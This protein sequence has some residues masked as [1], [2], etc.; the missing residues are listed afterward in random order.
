MKDK[1]HISQISTACPHKYLFQNTSVYTN[2]SPSCY[3]SL[4]TASLQHD[5][6]LELR[7]PR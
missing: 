6:E 4:L 1:V 7:S 5:Q 3:D 2:N